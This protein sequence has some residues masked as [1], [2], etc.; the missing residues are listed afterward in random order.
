MQSRFGLS[1]VFS[2]FLPST[3]RSP[4]SRS[5]STFSQSKLDRLP[6]WLP[7]KVCGDPV[8]TWSLHSRTRSSLQL[9]SRAIRLLRFRLSS[10]F[11]FLPRVS[12][13]FVWLSVYCSGV[14]ELDSCD[15]RVLIDNSSVPPSCFLSFW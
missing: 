1:R 11:V 12:A 8:S 9:D 3:C 2:F 15:N 5:H 6:A 14:T 13:K 7:Y 4:P 10:R